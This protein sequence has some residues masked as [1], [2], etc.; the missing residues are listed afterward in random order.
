MKRWT[1]FRVACLVW[2]MHHRVYIYPIPSCQIFDVDLSKRCAALFQTLYFCAP[3]VLSNQEIGLYVSKKIDSSKYYDIYDEQF[4]CCGEVQFR[5]VCKT[6]G[7]SMECM[8][9]A[10]DSTTACDCWWIFQN[11]FYNCPNVL[12][13]CKRVTFQSL[14]QTIASFSSG[15]DIK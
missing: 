5:Y 6:H 14:H 4:L 2:L 10:F 3:I 13:Y 15:D 12:D 9:C 11:S 7:N 1:T 8:F